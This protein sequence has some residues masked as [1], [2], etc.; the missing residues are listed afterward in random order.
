MARLDGFD[1]TRGPWKNQLMTFV[2]PFFTLFTFLVPAE[3][4]LKIKSFEFEKFRSEASRDSNSQHEIFKFDD[5]IFSQQSQW[6]GYHP[7]GG[8]DMPPTRYL[9]TKTAL[10]KITAYLEQ[11]KLTEFQVDPS[12]KKEALERDDFKVT[13]GYR[14]SFRPEVGGASVKLESTS[15]GGE[16][17]QKLDSLYELLKGLA[18]SEKLKPKVM[19]AAER[20]DFHHEQMTGHKKGEVPTSLE[21]MSFSRTDEPLEHAKGTLTPPFL[22]Q[23]DGHYLLVRRGGIEERYEGLPKEMSEQILR[24][25]I[26]KGFYRDG[27][28]ND[29]LGPDSGKAQLTGKRTYKMEIAFGARWTNRVEYQLLHYL[30]A[31]LEKPTTENKKKLAA[32]E[33]LERA[34]SELASSAEM[35]KFKRK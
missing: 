12:T 34:L 28:N 33:D 11:N 21:R 14:F 2:I 22:F 30:G 35:Q 8:S 10:R 27:L 1:E 32:Y 15:G 6:R 29:Y 31:P 13:E 19:S 16:L 23:T 4:K 26:Q 20:E 24:I 5:G 9:M 17:H 25:L 3:A 18:H 7:G